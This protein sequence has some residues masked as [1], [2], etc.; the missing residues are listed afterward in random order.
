M[1]SESSESLTFKN[2]FTFRDN[3]AKITIFFSDPY[4]VKIEREVRISTTTFLG[5]LA[6]VDKYLRF[7]D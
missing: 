5:F 4:Y 3:L 2:L 6:I 1:Q 7:N